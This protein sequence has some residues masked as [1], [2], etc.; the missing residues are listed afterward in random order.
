MPQIREAI[1]HIVGQLAGSSETLT[2]PKDRIAHW[3][4][5]Y[6][7]NPNEVDVLTEQISQIVNSKKPLF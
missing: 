3:L 1:E 2:I 6:F 4:A 7:D 5:M